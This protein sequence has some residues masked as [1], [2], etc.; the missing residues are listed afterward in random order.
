MRNVAAARVVQPSAHCNIMRPLQLLSKARGIQIACSSH[1]YGKIFNTDVHERALSVLRGAQQL[2]WP[3]WTSKLGGTL[4]VSD[5]EH[6]S[7]V[8]QAAREGNLSF[9]FSAGG[10]LFAYYIGVTGALQDAGVLNNNTKLGGASAGSLIAACVASKMPLDEITEQTMRLL[11]DCR[12]YGTRGRLGPV[13]ESFLEKHLPED[14]HQLCSGRAYVAVTKALPYARPVLLNEYKSR[15]DLISALM[16][17]CHIPWYLDGTPWTDFRG[18][19]HLD[20]GLTNFIPVVPGTVG[21]RV[22]CFPSRQLSPIYR[23]GISPDSYDPDWPYSLRQML[24]WALQA[25]DDATVQYLIDKGK[26]DAQAWMAAMGLDAFAV[27]SADAADSQVAA[28]KATAA[29]TGDREAQA[30]QAEQGTRKLEE[31]ANQQ[32]YA[33]M[34]S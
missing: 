16:T 22:C 10:C 26:Q 12:L 21:I 11:H 13:L 20:G 19:Y 32:D 4:V 3:Q 15:D 5:D 31:K 1:K 24:T 28:A 34:K 18:Q 6:R 29:G 2:D 33:R 30:A 9:G 7:F 25:A 23:I 27:H 8:Q 17:S 14:A